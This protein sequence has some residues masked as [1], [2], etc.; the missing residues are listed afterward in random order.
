MY[1]ICVFL[2][3]D[4]TT[5]A[6]QRDVRHCIEYFETFLSMSVKSGDRICLLRGEH[7][8]ATQDQGPPI[9]LLVGSAAMFPFPCYSLRPRR[10]WYNYVAYSNAKMELDWGD[11]ARCKHNGRLCW[12]RIAF[13]LIGVTENT[14][15]SLT[16]MPL[17]R[18][19]GSPVLASLVR[20]GGIRSDRL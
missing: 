15:S 7:E 14:G 2:Y 1:P 6:S 11:G 10:Y 17:S 8:R 20:C 16:L 9:V 13:T 12:M 5:V 18:I 3:K 4:S 19:P